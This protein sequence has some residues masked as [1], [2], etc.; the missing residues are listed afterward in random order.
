MVMLDPLKEIFY[1]GF[2]IHAL[3]VG[4]VDLDLTDVGLHDS[5]IVAQRF[6]EK[7]LVAHFVHDD[8]ANELAS[9]VGRVGSIE[10]LRTRQNR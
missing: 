1:G 6:D 5:R 4:A 9:F 10:N 8:F 2:L 3:I 7:E